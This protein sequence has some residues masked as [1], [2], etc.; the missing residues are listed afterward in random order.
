MFRPLAGA[1]VGAML[2]AALL[3]ATNRVLA[4]LVTPMQSIEHWVVYLSVVLG[5][6]FGAVAAA[7]SRHEKKD[8]GHGVEQ[9]VQENRSR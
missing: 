5:A 4:L 6:G 8:A 7:T 9:G 2:A 3:A 1:V